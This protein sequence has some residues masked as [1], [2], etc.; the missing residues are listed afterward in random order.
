MWSGQPDSVVVSKVP[1]P[2][3]RNEG[4]D[5]TG[6]NLVIYDD[7]HGYCFS[8][9]FLQTTSLTFNTK[10]KLVRNI[11]MS[12]TFSPLKD[13]NISENITRKFNVTVIKD[14]KGNIIKHEY[15]YSIKG[16]TDI[17][18]KKIR[19]VND[20]KFFSEGDLKQAGL[21]GQQLWR[22][23]GKYVTIVEGELDALAVSEMFDGKWPVVS[24]K[25]GAAGARKDIKEHLEWLETF[26]NVVV[27]FDNDPAGQ[28]ATQDVLPLFSHGK[29]K[30]VALPLKDAGDMLKNGK[31]REFVSA[32][33]DAKPY[34]PVDV[35]SFSDER[36]WD[37]FV[38]RG[39]EEII[40]LPEA[41]GSLNAMMNGGIAAGE[42]TVIGALTSIGKTTMV[43]NLLYDMVTQGNKKI[44]AVFLEADIGEIAEKVVSLHS[45]EN[46]SLVPQSQRD[47][48]AYRNFYDDF[49]KNENVYLLEH[50]GMS[51]VDALFAKMRW[52]AKGIDCDV[53]IVDP[54]HAAVRSD[55]NGTIDAF[56][57]RCLKLAKETGVSIIIISHMRKP[58]VK[59]PHDVNEYDMKGSGSI[60]QI[61]FNTILLS[62]DKMAAD[63]YTRNSTLVQLVK[64]RRTGRTGQAG[65]LYYEE[66]SGRMIQG[67]APELKAVEDEEF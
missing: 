8:C 39:T 18:G 30:T 9:G 19:S 42:V 13:R 63:E 36:V 10:P 14:D 5:S 58:N 15:P 62:R 65:W 31:V 54:L 3:C 47:N 49:K 44:G 26:E 61:A 59:D 24:L 35:V 28:K 16:G 4:R 46:I 25:T 57:D 12:G 7:G 33:W 67:T 20:K 11:E 1:C 50:L 23:G 52:M 40:P 66:N 27:C 43:F 6:D 22:E 21:F 45:G 38:K 48:S 37:A 64:C 41:Y 53:L 56:M 55:E 32:W 29:V 2:S 34:R 51:D 17:V 60:N